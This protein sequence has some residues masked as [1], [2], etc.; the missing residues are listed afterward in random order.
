MA[1]NRRGFRWETDLVQAALENSRLRDMLHPEFA[2]MVLTEPR[3]LFGVPDAVFTTLDYSG[4]E[5]RC[6]P[7]TALEMKLR[8]WKR[9]LT[10]A[11]RYRSFAHTTYVVLDAAHARP[12]IRE[13]ERFRRSKVGLIT[14]DQNGVVEFHYAPE[15]DQPVCEQMTQR[16]FDVFTTYIEAP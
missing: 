8:N 16:F 10:Q 5:W 13:L 1:V 15:P 14:V 2:P 12:A 6:G 9:A 7:T 11:F 4:G 3:G